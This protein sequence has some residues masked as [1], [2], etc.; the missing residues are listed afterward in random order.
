MNG[1]KKS[2]DYTMIHLPEYYSS[3][4]YGYVYEHI[5]NF[6][7]YHKCCLLPWSNI[8][9]IIP[10]KEGG[11]NLPYNLQGMMN[12][13]HTRIH[14]I[15]NKYGLKNFEGFKCSICGSNDTVKRKSNGRPRWYGNKHEIKCSRCYQRDYDNNRRVRLSYS[16]TR[17][18]ST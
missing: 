1:R 18:K 9:H 4:K 15:G 8:H 10:V 7:E 16:T 17:T 11:S 3:N 12:H 5:Y 6:Q 2:G 13:K 14:M